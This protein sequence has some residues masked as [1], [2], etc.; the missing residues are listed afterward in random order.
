LRFSASGMAVCSLRLVA[1][2]R[3]LNQQTNEWEDGD[4]LWF[5]AVCFKQLAENTVESVVKGDKVVVTGKFKTEEW[6]NQEGEK[7][8][9]IS[10]TCDT[11]S[12]SLAY[13]TVKITKASRSGGD[14]ASQPAERTN[15]PWASQ[16][17]EP[18]F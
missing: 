12:A 16:S 18:P 14:R 17:D 9:K 4:K 1:S 10:F 2:D 6:T 15:D 11:V 3:R 7:R 8:S 5:D 13:A